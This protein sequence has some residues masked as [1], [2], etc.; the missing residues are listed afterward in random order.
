MDEIDQHDKIC[1]GKFQFIQQ[2]NVDI[3]K[4]LNDS[5]EFISKSSQVLKQFQIGEIELN[6][7]LNQSEIV[8][9]NSD[10]TKEKLEID[11][12]NKYLIKFDKQNLDSNSIGKIRKKNVNL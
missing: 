6:A 3:K 12:F 4:E 11:M 9:S 7:S 5:N 2:N 8:F 1:Q 10:E